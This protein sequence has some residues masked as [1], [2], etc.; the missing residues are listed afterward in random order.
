MQTGKAIL[1]LP[2]WHTWAG[3]EWRVLGFLESWVAPAIHCSVALVQVLGW[4][5]GAKFQPIDPSVSILL[6]CCW[7][8]QR[9]C[10]LKSPTFALLLWALG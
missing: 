10:S 2:T 4:R 6:H 1:V 3:S 8:A 7:V 9:Y 5:L